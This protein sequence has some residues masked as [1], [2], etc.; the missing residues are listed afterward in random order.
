MVDLLIHPDE[1]RTMCLKLKLKYDKNVWNL[2][3][4]SLYIMDFSQYNDFLMLLKTCV[5]SINLPIL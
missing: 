5:A 4:F 1:K 2:K 3:N